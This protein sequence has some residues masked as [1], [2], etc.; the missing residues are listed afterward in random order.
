MHLGGRGR[1]GPPPG[2]GALEEGGQT[3]EGEEEV[4]GQGGGGEEA[5]VGAPVQPLG[6]ETVSFQDFT[7]SHSFYSTMAESMS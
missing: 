5:V 4:G 1:A 2:Q 7:N 3:Q 6:G